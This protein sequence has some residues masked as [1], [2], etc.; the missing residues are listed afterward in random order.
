MVYRVV[1]KPHTID[2]STIADCAFDS[3]TGQMKMSVLKQQVIPHF[4]CGTDGWIQ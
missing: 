3:T 2:T 4:T 1:T